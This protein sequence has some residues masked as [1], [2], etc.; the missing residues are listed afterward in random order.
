MSQSKQTEDTGKRASTQLIRAGQVATAITA[1]ITAGLLIWTQLKGAGP[2]AV[3]RVSITSRV[4]EAPRTEFSYFDSHPAE[5]AREEAHLHAL[6]D[7]SKQEIQRE[8][9]RKNG[10]TVEFNVETQA[11]AGHTWHVN[12]TLFNATTGARVEEANASIPP[13]TY[14]PAAGIQ[15]NPFPGWFEYP[16]HPGEYYVELELNDGK[17]SQETG[18]TE[19]FRAP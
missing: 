8:L 7:L 14:T 15:T 5:L 1:L 12:E 13:E 4:P 11:P 16:S 2:P 19:K 18:K 17:G 9:E 10:V 6:Y 3:L